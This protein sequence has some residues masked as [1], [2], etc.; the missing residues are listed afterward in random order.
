MQAWRTWVTGVCMAAACGA[1]AAQARVDSSSGP[2]ASDRPASRFYGTARPQA[3][4]VAP[5]PVHVAPPP[6]FAPP[7]VVRPGGPPASVYVPPPVI[8]PPAYRPPYYHRPGVG[9]DVIIGAPYPRPYPY[10][11]GTW[12]YPAYPPPVIVGPPIVVSP[13]PPP[14]VYV[15]RPR[16]EEPPA[17]GFW[18]W[19]AAPQGWYPEVND[20][21]QGWQP[22]PPRAAQ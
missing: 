8:R 15:E 22:V 3:P 6:S 5:P 9:V 12:G 16:D 21:P 2:Q 19:C 13:P 17:D 20:C 18:Y 4:G 7:A 1:A 11:P 14:L 10:Y